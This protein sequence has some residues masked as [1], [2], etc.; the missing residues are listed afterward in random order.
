MGRDSSFESN[1]ELLAHKPC[2]CTCTHTPQSTAPVRILKRNVRYHSNYDDEGIMSSNTTL[3]KSCLHSGYWTKWVKITETSQNI[4]EVELNKM[5]FSQFIFLEDQL[6]I[7]LCQ[8]SRKWY[9]VVAAYQ[10]LLL[11][12]GTKMKGSHRTASWMEAIWLQNDYF[13]YTLI[14]L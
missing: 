2:T 3:R 14:L 5:W 8:P 13:K 11:V 4:A 7:Y 10:S 12:V 9:A 6:R 1:E